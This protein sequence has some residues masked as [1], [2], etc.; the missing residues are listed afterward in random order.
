MS[1]L[2]REINVTGMPDV[3]YRILFNITSD[4]GKLEVMLF[5]EML[6][7]FRSLDVLWDL[8]VMSHGQDKG[9]QR[10]RAVEVILY[11]DDEGNYQ[12]AKTTLTD[13]LKSNSIPYRLMSDV[14]D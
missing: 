1:E 9:Q 10:A 12:N 4:V 6:N 13:F 8:T 3:A 7:R 14:T 2:A 5:A 11:R